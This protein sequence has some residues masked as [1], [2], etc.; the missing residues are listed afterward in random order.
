MKM[1]NETHVLTY[2]VY[3]KKN[4][5]IILSHRSFDCDK[6]EYCKCSVEYVKTLAEEDDLVI[7]RVT[8]NDPKNLDVLITDILPENNTPGTS[9]FLVDVKNKKIIEKPTIELTSKKIQL[10]GD[11]KDKSIVSI[12]VVDKKGKTIKDFNGQIKVITSRGKLS[13]KAG[14]VELNNGVGEI[15]ITSVNETVS[16]VK[17]R[18]SST[19]DN[20]LAGGVNLEYV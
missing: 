7:S 16:Q 12:N 19:D 11:G 13:A 5:A 3:D 2:I 4:G 17:V 6:E 8:N 1:E 9:D 14:I 20:V 15:S 10:N 18:A